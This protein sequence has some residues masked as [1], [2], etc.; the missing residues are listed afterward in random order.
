M[1][2][3][4]IVDVFYDARVLDHDTGSGMWEREPSPLL[5]EQ[6]Q[7][8]EGPH[9]VRNMRSVLERGP[10]SEHLRWHPGR[11]ATEEEL[12]RVHEAAYVQAVRDACEAGGSWLTA[13]TVVSAGS[14]IPLLAAAGTSL[15]AAEAVL[16]GHSSKSYALVRPPGHHAQ[17]AQADGYCVFCHP[18]LVAEAARA[19]GYGR[20][21][22]VDWDVHH[23]NG[24]QEIFYDRPDVLTISLHMDHGAWGPSHRQTGSPDECG[25]GEG[26]G[27]NLNVA[28]PVGSG[29]DAY[30]AAFDEIVAPV[31]SAFAPDL[32]VGACGQDG[33]TFDPEGRQNLTMAGFHGI[34]RRVGAFADR[35][36][37]GRLVLVQ[38]G[39]YARSYAAYCLHATLEG[40]LQLPGRLQDPLA[41]IPDDPHHADRAIASAR[42]VASQYWDL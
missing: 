6:E 26:K 3:T 10:V 21:A 37:D 38:E 24:T 14:W 29:N 4:G 7:H 12:E 17:R 2:S 19:A 11:L 31:L 39:G 34:G 23:G 40:V 16:S 33:S 28:L 13:T 35:H 42:D 27:F 32:I 8:P 25:A 9:R 1:T 41:Y 18:A 36:C 20:V 22:I 30:L 5:D 15:A